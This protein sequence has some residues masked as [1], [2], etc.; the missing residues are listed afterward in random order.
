MA[1]PHP[2]LGPALL[3]GALIG[4]SLFLL[5]VVAAA[6]VVPRAIGA[7]PMPVLTGSMAPTFSAGDLIVVQTVAPEDLSVGDIVTF[8]PQGDD[9]TPLTHR[10]VKIT[11]ADGRV[12]SLTTQG[13]T[14]ASADAPI[15]P[16]QVL[17]RY[18]YRMPG[19]GFV[20]QLTPTE[21]AD[22]K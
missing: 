13:D 21:S 16:G 12:Q 1:A 7:V 10:V 9:L 20:A 14:D 4:L 15:V 18:L 6:V 3:R 17:G 5:V 22:S 19:L 8:R 11:R 2:E